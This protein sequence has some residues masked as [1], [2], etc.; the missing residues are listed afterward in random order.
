MHDQRLAHGPESVR[1]RLW[2]L[3]K[4]DA[5]IIL[6]SRLLLLVL[7][8]YP[9]VIVSIIGYAFSQP[10]QN[11][12][13]AVVNRDVDPATGQPRVGF[14]QN[15]IQG[16]PSSLPVSSRDI[17]DGLEPFADLRHVTMEEGLD[18]LLA[19]DVYA[20]ILFPQGFVDDIIRYESS[21]R[22]QITIDKSDAVRANITETMI[23]GIV[24][25]FQEEIIASKVNL[26]VEAINRSLRTTLA[27]NDPL[28]PGFPGVRD[29]LLTIRDA[30]PDL[31]PEQRL[32]LN[33]SLAFLDQVIATLDNSRGILDS[34]A[35]PVHVTIQQE[36]SGSLLIR[37]LVV[38]A[39]LGLSIFWTGT[40][41]TSSLV[42][43]EREAAAYTRLRITPTS[44]ITIYSSK[45]LL[46]TGVILLQSLAI[47]A[48][49]VWR[50][51]TRVDNP[52]LTLVLV[53]LSTFAS[54]GLGI[55]VSGL[56]RDVNGS[57][58][59]SVLVTFPMLFLSGLF[60]PVDFMPA[61]AQF[62]AR[63]FPLTYT[64]AGL[65]GSMLRGFDFDAAQTDITA[66][67]AFGL[68]AVM[69]G[70]LLGRRLERR[71]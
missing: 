30:H 9:L 10:N 47:L 43:Y 25:V 59:L 57:V 54:I 45:V 1:V 19:G 66:L 40:L 34:V 33:E 28:Y 67:L 58:L 69:A 68:V 16:Q 21:G 13:I 7:L 52:G 6:R 60:Y 24:Q 62:L 4:K 50:W 35:K 42:V 14:I 51:D 44:P 5:R 31:T 46:T 37:D 27:T 48:A 49:A 70:I 39:A 22:V 23:R 18:M 38:P 56:G 15:P 32:M 3:L 55:L 12:P 20:V 64:V 26:V 61:G 53:V 11:V 65:R 71:A 41:A 36:E 29:R 17:I 2:T 63:L 8:L